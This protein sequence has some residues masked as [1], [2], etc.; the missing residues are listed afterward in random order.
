[1]PAAAQRSGCGFGEGLAALRVA[2]PILARLAEA[3]SAG[4]EA[5]AA[6]AERLRAARTVLAGCGC[7]R[8]ASDAGEA[9]ML[10][11][12]A[13]GEASLPRLA[14]TLERARFSLRLARERLDR[15]GCS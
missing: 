1:M 5:G 13:G 10:A 9:A 12:Q 15:A 4:R 2:D 3:L 11:E 8:A 6:A 7:R 14:A